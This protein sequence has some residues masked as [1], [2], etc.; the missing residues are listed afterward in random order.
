MVVDAAGRVSADSDVVGSSLKRS[1][2]IGT[3]LVSQVF[4]LVD[5]ICAGDPRLDELWAWCR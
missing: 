4:A 1:D 5:A 2:V 3:P